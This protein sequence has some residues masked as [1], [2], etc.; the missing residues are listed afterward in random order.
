MIAWDSPLFYELKIAAVFSVD[1]RL[2][3]NNYF[4][5]KCSTSRA[6]TPHVF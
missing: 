1:M 2:N 4:S 5:F 6:H 3:M